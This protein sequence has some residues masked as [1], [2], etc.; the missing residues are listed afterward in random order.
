MRVKYGT[1]LSG[2]LPNQRRYLVGGLGT[3]RGYD[4]QSLLTGDRPP[5]AHGGQQMLLAN[6]E[7]TFDL[8][9]SRLWERS[10]HWDDDREPADRRG[11][12]GLDLALFFDSGM[13]GRT[14]RQRSTWMN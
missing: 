1:A 2:S 11:H 9:W 3:V 4:Y 5:G 6:A 10:R 12:R 8:D 13:A 7:I 14:G